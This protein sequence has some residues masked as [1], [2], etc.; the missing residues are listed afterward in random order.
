VFIIHRWA[1]RLEVEVVYTP[2]ENHINPL[3][4]ALEQKM[5][6]EEFEQLV[7]AVKEGQISSGDRFFHAL[8]WTANDGLTNHIMVL[9][10]HGGDADD[11]IK[12]LE[13]EGRTRAANLLRWCASNQKGQTLS[14]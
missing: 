13:E 4:L 9:L 8:I 12:N 14:R 11:P 3:A 1:H 6:L 5:P 7:I 10:R 2:L